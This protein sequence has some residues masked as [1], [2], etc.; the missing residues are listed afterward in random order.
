MEI[1]GLSEGWKSMPLGKSLLS[2]VNAAAAWLGQ[3]RRS[4]SSFASGIFDL[5]ATSP[6]PWN[7]GTA[8]GY[9]SWDQVTSWSSHGVHASGSSALFGPV[10]D[11]AS[12]PVPYFGTFKGAAFSVEVI[13]GDQ[14]VGVRF[15][16]S[17]KTFVLVGW[18]DTSVVEYWS[19]IRASALFDGRG[20]VF[21]QDVDQTLATVGTYG[22]GYAFEMS[23]NATGQVELYVGGA[24]TPLW[25]GDPSL[26]PL[27]FPMRLGIFLGCVGDAVFDVQ[28]MVQLTT[29]TTIAAPTLDGG[30]QRKWAA[31]FPP[32]TPSS[33]AR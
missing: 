4:A 8:S 32:S 16:P 1:S 10:L 14:I 19:A 29:T 30:A 21:A 26:P 6:L 2:T 11:W 23:V 25:A 18:L 3:E 22:A 13:D 15:V 12:L 20:N 17:P 27:P 31:A 33:S 5:T 28:W 24:E 9:W 7:Y